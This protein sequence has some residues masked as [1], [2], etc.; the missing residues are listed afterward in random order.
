MTKLLD[1][2]DKKNIKQQLESFQS[3]FYRTKKDIFFSIVKLNSQESKELLQKWLREGKIKDHLLEVD[4]ES[5][6]KY[7]FQN[8]SSYSDYLEDIIYDF[9]GLSRDELISSLNE[10][11]FKIKDNFD[12]AFKQNQ[13][14]EEKIKELEAEQENLEAQVEELEEQKFH[15]KS[16]E[17]QKWQKAEIVAK[18]DAIE[19]EL[20]R[21]IEVLENNINWLENKE[22]IVK[23]YENKELPALP[24]KQKQSRLLKFKKLVNKVK[25]KSKEKFQTHVLEKFEAYILQPK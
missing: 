9:R 5:Y 6:K 4:E 11:T 2:L 17:W 20:L 14:Y 13:E 18:H 15:K 10:L 12:K 7:L 25:E 3:M 1:I 24:K 21:K 22:Q 23:K 8:F 16:E 19:K